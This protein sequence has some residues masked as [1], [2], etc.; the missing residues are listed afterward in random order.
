MKER[1]SAPAKVNLRLDIVGRDP[2]SGHHHLEMVLAP[3]TLADEMMVEESDRLTVVTENCPEP[4]PQERNIVHRIVRAVEAEIGHELPPLAV[5]IRKEIPTGG[6]MGGGS[7]DGATILRYLDERYAL[8][9]GMERMTRI[10]ARVG[11]DIPFFLHR[12]PAVVSGFGDRVAPFRMA[13][14]PFSLLLVH[15]GFPVDTKAAYALW[16]RKMLTKRAPTGTNTARVSAF[17]SLAEWRDFM[18]NDFEA[19]LF[20]EYPALAALARRLAEEGADRSL[21]TGSGSTVVGFFADAERR[22]R[23]SGRLREEYGFVR[24]AEIVG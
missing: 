13:A 19:P 4:I 24:K 5:T 22:E 20:E 11:S 2:A 18:R 6:G 7:S 15:P 9:L 12:S 21:M 10:A 16:D 23:A 1:L 17:R 14:F 8:C 3:V